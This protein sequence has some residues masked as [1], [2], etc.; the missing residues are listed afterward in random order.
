MLKSTIKRT[1]LLLGIHV[2]IIFGHSYLLAN[3]ET[4]E[5]CIKGEPL[6]DI[7]HDWAAHGIW[8]FSAFQSID[9]A[10]IILILTITFIV[11]LFFHPQRQLLFRRFLI[12]HSTMSVIRAIFIWVTTLPSPTALCYDRY[13]DSSE[14]LGRSIALTFGAIGIPYEWYEIGIPGMTCCDSI[15]SG[16][17]A[18]LLVLSLLLTAAIKNSGV[19]IGI[20]ALAILGML[21]LITVEWH[22]TIDVFAAALI[23]ILFYKWYTLKAT[24]KAGW[25]IKYL[26]GDLRTESEN[27]VKSYSLKNLIKT[28]NNEE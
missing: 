7:V 10:S 24:V 6:Y 18:M 26:E 17:T 27:G 19:R 8:P 1:L 9:H 11:V 4:R 15:I 2:L 21:G 14:V 22:Y 20:W 12:L 13:I 3:G 28:T 5:A 16:H 25:L 23:G